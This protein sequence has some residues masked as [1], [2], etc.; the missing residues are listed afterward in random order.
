VRG[1]FLVGGL[2]LKGTIFGQRLFLDGDCFWMEIVFKEE[3]P[4]KTKMNLATKTGLQFD[5]NLLSSLLFPSLAA[6]ELSM[7]FA[8][9]LS[10]NIKSNLIC[11]VIRTGNLQRAEWRWKC[12]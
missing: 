11:P 10:M 7:L 6:S 1:L 4:F 9:L 3:L 2:F 8:K 5:D 12:R